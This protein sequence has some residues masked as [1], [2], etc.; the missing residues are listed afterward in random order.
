MSLPPLSISPRVLESLQRQLVE[1]STLLNLAN[2]HISHQ[3][4]QIRHLQA[5][6]AFYQQAQATSVQPLTVGVAGVEGAVG[7]V[8]RGEEVKQLRLLVVHLHGMIAA[9]DEVIGEQDKELCY[10]QQQ[11]RQLKEAREKEVEALAEAER[12]R[13]SDRE[14]LRVLEAE[15]AKMKDRE[16]DR[17]DRQEWKEHTQPLSTDRRAH[18]EQTEEQMRQ[19]A[20]EAARHRGEGGHQE[21]LK[22]VFASSAVDQ[23]HPAS[24]PPVLPFRAQSEP[25]TAAI[26]EPPPAEA[27][28]ASSPSSPAVSSS[29]V[30]PPAPAGHA[31][32]LALSPLSSP[33]S[34]A[35]T[36]PRPLLPK[37]RRS[38]P[39]SA[40][41]SPQI[42]PQPAPVDA[43]L[44]PA[45]SSLTATR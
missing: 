34:A 3:A 41:A 12:E 26:A 40:R 18:S 38:G 14:R 13:D 31:S 2:D 43:A 44:A 16:R 19:L 36:T 24:A 45:T 6:M 27:A 7:G 29:A 10:Y 1:K 35:S 25:A 4:V 8:G 28:S 9:R 30:S 23:Q 39:P 15:V 21:E 37:V 42:Q 11:L 5:K 20:Q 22:Q 32:P 33:S 17:K